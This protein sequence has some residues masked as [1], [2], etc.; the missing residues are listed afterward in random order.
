ML[1]I[2]TLLLEISGYRQHSFDSSRVLSYFL[3][4]ALAKN[5]TPQPQ[6]PSPCTAQ[7]PFLTLIQRPIHG[8]RLKIIQDHDGQPA[9][10]RQQLLIAPVAILDAQSSFC[11]TLCDLFTASRPVG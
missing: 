11:T 9:N 8:P 10:I 3:G 1:T 5:S 7:Q 6:Q 4:P 2:Y